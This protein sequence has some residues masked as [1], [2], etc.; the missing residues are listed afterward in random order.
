MP[1]NYTAKPGSNRGL[2]TEEDLKG[3]IEAVK[4]GT[5]VRQA[6][7]TFNIPRKTLERRVKTGNS[8]KGSMG[9]SGTLGNDNECRLVRH[10]KNMQ[11]HGFPMTR[12]DV[13]SLAYNFAEELGLRHKFSKE[14]Q[15]AGYDWLHLF[16][17]R[18]PD[19]S[20][21]KSEGVSLARAQEMNRSEVNDYFE[22]LRNVFEENC[23]FNKPCALF[24][25]DETGL[26]L[27]NRPGHVIAGKG[28]KSVPLVTSSE[29]GETITLVACCN[30]EG[31]FL[32][33]VVIMKGKN[34]KPEFEDGM[35][36]GSVVYMSEKS[37]YINSVIFSD[38]LRQHFLPRKPAGK[39]VLIL[40]GHSSHCNSVQLLEFAKANDII[41]ICLP[42]H[43]THFL[44]PL[45]RAVFKSVKSYFY[46]AAQKWLKN[47][48]TRKITRLQF[49]QLLNECWGKSA[50]PEN[51]VSA[52]KATGIYPFNPDAI[53][54]YAFIN[55]N[56]V[57]ERHLNVQPVEENVNDAENF[58]THK[59]ATP[60]PQPSISRLNAE[61]STTVEQ[62]NFDPQPGPSGLNVE[63]TPTKLLQ[64]ISP[65][66][67]INKLT[68]KRRKLHATILTSPENMEKVKL[69][70]E[71]TNSKRKPK[72]VPKMKVPRPKKRTVSSSSSC[73]D[74]PDI[75]DFS[76]DEINND[77]DECV[78]CGENYDQTKLKVDW[79]KC[80]RCQRWLHETCSSFNDV[81]IPCGKT[82]TKNI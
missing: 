14:T 47:H 63:S 38:W 72:K 62:V 64:A 40:D 55:V 31:M 71:K 29:K 4:N 13:R 46:S 34:K 19:L 68:S 42:S 17:T 59:Q 21:R 52:F 82:I 60:E 27:N 35:P 3:A 15:K 41:L 20:I 48:P 78:G 36:P 23:L 5:S 50:T 79:I 61:N 39:F 18:H 28:S 11:Q 25:M 54:Q 12:T 44:Q 30:A 10:I 73:S 81:C 9:P 16:L 58:N 33:P 51:A 80:V 49:G 7:I 43:T 77:S 24:N 26:Q 67:A 45:D 1:T 70:A 22:L 2:W 75:N 65:L 74:V 6:S 37:A 56:T 53:P 8:T 66:P 76:S 57:E 32:P 69:K